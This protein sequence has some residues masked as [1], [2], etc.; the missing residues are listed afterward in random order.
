MPEDFYGTESKQPEAEEP[1]MEESGEETALVPKSMLG[2]NCKVGDTY[3]VKVAGIYDNE[4]ELELVKEK[5][6]SKDDS[7]PDVEARM[8]AMGGS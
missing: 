5:E 2:G 4:A 3:K 6:E 8:M 1:E 7:E